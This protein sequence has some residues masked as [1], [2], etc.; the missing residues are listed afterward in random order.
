VS[1]PSGGFTLRGG[2][3]LLPGGVSIPVAWSRQLS[4]ALTS[5]RVYQASLGHGY[6]SL[7]A[8]RQVELAPETGGAIVVHWGVT[9]TATIT[10]LGYD[11]PHLGHGKRCAAELCRAQCRTSRRRAARGQV[12]SKG[13]L[14]AQ[15]QAGKLHRKAASQNK[16]ASRIWAKSV[17]DNPQVIAV[18]VLTPLLLATSTMARKSA[19]GAIGAATAEL[20]DLGTRAGAPVVRVAPVYRAMTCLRCC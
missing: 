14:R 8:R 11:L 17:V 5:L 3:L 13:Y 7:V 1:T 12:L 4:C 2:R 16:H 15:R 6:T 9:T 10:D 18:E 20:I 19:D